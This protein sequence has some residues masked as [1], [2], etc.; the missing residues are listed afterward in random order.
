MAHDES[1]TEDRSHIQTIVLVEHKDDVVY[2]SCFAEAQA[3][4]IIWAVRPSQCLAQAY[5]TFPND[6][7]VAGN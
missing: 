6:R 3:S 2:T 7:K 5:R 4:V 1:I